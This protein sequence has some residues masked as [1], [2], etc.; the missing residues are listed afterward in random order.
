MKGISFYC[1]FLAVAVVYQYN[2]K[3]NLTRVIDLLFTLVICC[4]LRT[5]R[6][7]LYMKLCR[8]EYFFRTSKFINKT[9]N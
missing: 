5:A 2:N 1:T 9:L 7:F 6:G 3:N 8:P 4:V